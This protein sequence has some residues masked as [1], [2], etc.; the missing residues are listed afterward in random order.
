MVGVSNKNHQGKPLL[1]EMASRGWVCFAMNYP[2]S[3]RAKFP[4][5]I[6]AVKRAIAWIREHAH[7]YGGDAWFLM[8]SGNSAGGHLSSLA[9]LTPN[10][11]DYQPGFEGADTS[12]QAAAPLYGVYD[13]T[14][15]MLDELSRGARR[16]K[17]AA[18]RHL[19]RLVLGR[20]LTNERDAFE[21]GSPWHRIGPHAPPFLVI[22]GSMDTLALVEEARAFAER[23]RDASDE[24]VIYAE[25]PR[26]QHAFDTFLSIRTLYAVRAIARFGEWCYER[27]KVSGADRE[28]PED[29]ELRSPTSAT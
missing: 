7:E 23:L 25:L 21:K 17:R 29:R 1:I 6:I 19:E 24:P 3:P 28:R 20:R 15:A 4:E 13:F 18:L 8:V 26:A 5:H 9:A 14:G 11:A 22:H 16:H 27:W 10:D 2:V 12:I